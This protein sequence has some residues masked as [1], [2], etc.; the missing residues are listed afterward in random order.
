VSCGGI[1]AIH[2]FCIVSVILFVK[3][4]NVVHASCH[5]SRV[6]YG[7]WFNKFLRLSI[8]KE[9]VD[10]KIRLKRS[11]L[12]CG[13]GFSSLGA[14]VGCGGGGRANKKLFGIFNDTGK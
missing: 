2:V 3:S 13:I 6:N 1:G 14:I 9:C 7:F 12:C 5:F 11:R 4:S 10:K 8:M